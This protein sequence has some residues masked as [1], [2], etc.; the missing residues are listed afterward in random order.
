MASSVSPISSQPTVAGLQQELALLQ[1]K[2]DRALANA[3]AEITRLKRENEALAEQ[4]DMAEIQKSSLFE[5]AKNARSKDKAKED[6][7]AMLADHQI[8]SD[9][10]RELK[11]AG[12]A[13]NHRFLSK[14][15][16]MVAWKGELQNGLV[17][18]IN[19][20][21]HRLQLAAQA[22]EDHSTIVEEGIASSDVGFDRFSA[23]LVAFENLL[24]DRGIWQEI[25][26]EEAASS[27]GAE[28]VKQEE[29]GEEALGAIDYDNISD[30]TLDSLEAMR[31][32]GGTDPVSIDAPKNPKIRIRP[33]IW[34]TKKTGDHEPDN[35]NTSLQ[36]GVKE[37]L[38]L[39]LPCALDLEGDG[40]QEGLEEEHGQLE[41]PAGN[42]L[43][44]PTQCQ[45]RL[46][47]IWA[48]LEGTKIQSEDM[49]T[50]AGSLLSAA[51]QIFRLFLKGAENDL[52][53]WI[54][55]QIVCSVMP[56]AFQEF[57]L[58]KTLPPD[59]PSHRSTRPL[60]CAGVS[61]ILMSATGSQD[62]AGKSYGLF[63][64]LRSAAVNA[65]DNCK[66]FTTEIDHNPVN[67]ALYLLHGVNIGDAWEVLILLETVTGDCIFWHDEAEKCVVFASED[68]AIWLKLVR[69]ASGHP[70]QFRVPDEL[71]GWMEEQFELVQGSDP[72]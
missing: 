67:A 52:G 2:T 12:E 51:N 66:Y 7:Q 31:L 36:R 62:E 54:T 59:H 40:D 61:R 57:D 43:L 35:E 39:A 34:P 6:Q 60:V 29:P 70:L 24:R 56:W 16:D 49:A 19:E 8:V 37:M 64:S 71:G 33:T 21:Q 15:R 26:V 44:H 10:F 14:K 4:L 46:W 69:V 65:P 68:F 11:D 23:T 63:T 48:T 18:I 27:I 30:R 50:L 5:E 9:C 1:K 17:T 72:E 20:L 3:A 38:D 25:P 55:A 13:V 45:T 28:L 47:G 41:D 53:F 32:P 42:D 58:S 22:V